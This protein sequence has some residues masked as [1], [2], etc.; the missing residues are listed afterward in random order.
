M[1]F[2][3]RLMYISS[4]ASDNSLKDPKSSHEIVKDLRDMNQQMQI[5]K[6]IIS[7]IQKEYDLSYLNCEV[8]KIFD[9][10]NK[11]LKLLCNTYLILT[12][13]DKPATQLMC[14]HTF[15]KDF[16]DK[17]WKIQ[18]LA[19]NHA[20]HLSDEIIIKN[21]LKDIKTLSKNSL[22]EIKMA[23]AKCLAVVF[24]KSKRLFLSEN[25]IDSIKSLLKDRDDRIKITMLNSISSI[26]STENIIGTME[27]LQI[28]KY[29]IYKNNK[30]GIRAILGV[31]KYKRLNNLTKDIYNSLKNSSDT[32]IIYFVYSKLIENDSSLKQEFYHKLRKF[33]N[34]SYEQR[35]NVFAF[36]C[37]VVNEI[38]SQS[39]DFSIFSTDPEYIKFIK[40]E[41][42]IKKY[43]DF[44]KNEIERLIYMK[45]NIL[46]IIEYSLKY[47]RYFN[48][49]F[50]YVSIEDQDKCLLLFQKYFRSLMVLENGS[51][52]MSPVW[53]DSIAE[54][55]QVIKCTIKQTQLFIEL[56]SK[57]SKT[58]PNIIFKFYTEKNSINLIKFYCTLMTRK[59]ISKKQCIN[60]LTELKKSIQCMPLTKLVINNLDNINPEDISTEMLNL[61][62]SNISEKYLIDFPIRKDFE[63]DL[64]FEK[65]FKGGNIDLEDDF[66]RNINLDNLFNDSSNNEETRI[67]HP[68]FAETSRFESAKNLNEYTEPEIQRSKSKSVEEENLIDHPIKDVISLK[69]YFVIDSEKFPIFVDTKDFKGIIRIVNNMVVLNVDIL[70]YNVDVKYNIIDDDK[71]FTH[72]S[73][74]SMNISKEGEY[75]L[76]SISVK[77]INSK[78]IFACSDYAF[79]I[80]LS[81]ENIISAYEPKDDTG[82]NDID[83]DSSEYEIR[84]F[85]IDNVEIRFSKFKIKNDT[86]VFELFDEIFYI[87]KIENEYK[88]LGKSKFLDQLL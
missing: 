15:L 43:D 84:D 14:V 29:F 63:T 38:Q 33:F 88:I 82:V 21:Y 40:I 73:I 54:F 22:F 81:L 8:I 74:N 17:N 35:Y 19:L 86:Y 52:V 75:I 70:E 42:M 18:R 46:Q 64:F 4:L 79:T 32:C 58:I 20:V 3:S 57:F 66:G 44:C 24:S 27:L 7:M 78:F 9:T 1:E 6:T 45:S 65:P 28:L 5:M 60:F 59:V 39:T 13:S 67:P 72:V 12:C 41:I 55:L 68:S 34:C 49:I 23:C 61:N 31:L 36:I 69:D 48:D 2:G 50:K 37:N 10:Y 16:N 87:R 25:M 53:T 80:N 62:S 11:N 26:E 30:K 83:M 47:N 71:E 56:A 77:N 76:S 51:M 85:N